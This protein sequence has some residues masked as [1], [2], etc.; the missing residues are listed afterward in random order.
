MSFT[1]I[2]RNLRKNQ[3]NA[4]QI[5]WQQL[6]N[7]RFLNYKFRRQFPIEPYIADF[8]CLGIKLIIELDGSQHNEQ[9]DKEHTHFLE[10][11]G[12]K[13]IRFW[14]HDLFNNLESVLEK[15]RLVIEDLENSNL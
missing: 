9:V 15:I 14:N 10:Q 2:A 4:E 13:V 6:R 7:R 8:V 5:L 3:T 1:H 12:F 11:L